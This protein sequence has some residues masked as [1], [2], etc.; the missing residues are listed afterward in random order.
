MLT[1]IPSSETVHRL[2][3]SHWHCH[4]H[5]FD[6]AQVTNADAKANVVRSFLDALFAGEKR[7]LIMLGRAGA[8]K[9]H[10]AASLYRAAVARW[11][12]TQATFV[13]VPTASKMVK[14]RFDDSTLPDPLADFETA[15][16]V[17]LD[18]P[19]GREP[20]DWDLNQTI[21]EMIDSAYRRRA[22]MVLTANHDMAGLNA[23]LPLHEVSR[24]M[25]N[26]TIMDFSNERDRRLG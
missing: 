23:R 26:A 8:G 10:L 18:D 4:L 13:H 17:V 3:E 7:N 20:T 9:T 15:R 25:E 5:N 22:C 12:L 2:P 24:L 21:P 14:A 16:L 1:D 11:D 6:W 19:L